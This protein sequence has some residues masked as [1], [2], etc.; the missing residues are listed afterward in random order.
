LENFHKLLLPSEG[1][2]SFI[3]FGSHQGI[4]NL[5][6]YKEIEKGSGK[7]IVDS[8]GVYQGPSANAFWDSIGC[9]G[10]VPL[11]N[12]HW[13]EDCV[14]LEVMSPYFKFGKPWYISGLTMGAVE[15]LGYSV[16]RNY[17]MTFGMEQL[18]SKCGN[19]CPEKGNSRRLRTN[20]AS[21]HPEVEAKIIE[22]AR[23]HFALEGFYRQS[24]SVLHQLNNQVVSRIVHRHDIK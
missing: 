8:S 1:I 11:Q 20:H 19:F 4:G 16:N 23:D 12:S 9:S 6:Q 15:D 13:A 2:S 24:V 7:F 3:C 18:G 10:P 5:W 22:R 21:A 14:D 17:E